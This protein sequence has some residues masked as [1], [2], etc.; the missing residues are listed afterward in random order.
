MSCLEHLNKRLQE[1]LSRVN[2]R[3]IVS[4]GCVLKRDLLKEG[5]KLARLDHI[6]SRRQLREQDCG[7]VT[8]LACVHAVLQTDIDDALHEDFLG[9]LRVNRCQVERHQDDD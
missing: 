7:T 9:A 4:R 8:D 6:G 5:V 3:S 2:H 1:T